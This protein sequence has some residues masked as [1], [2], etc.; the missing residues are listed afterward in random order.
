MTGKV[1]TVE[2]PLLTKKSKTLVFEEN[3]RFGRE[4]D[5]K[6]AWWSSNP[7]VAAAPNGHIFVAD[8]SEN[9]IMEYDAQGKWV[10]QLGGPGEGPGE[11]QLLNLYHI[12]E[13][14]MGVA[15]DAE[16]E[17]VSFSTFTKEGVFLAKEKPKRTR[18]NRAFFM[19]NGP[20]MGVELLAVEKDRVDIINGVTNH[21][22]DLKI[23]VLTTIIPPW[24]SSKAEDPVILGDRLGV[25]INVKAGPRGLVGFGFKG[26]VYT[27][28]S[29]KYEI[30]RWSA[31]LKT[32][33]LL[34]RKQYK[35][36]FRSPEE[37][38]M[39]IE[40]LAA[41]F[42]EALKPLAH[43]IT[44]AMVTKS[45]EKSGMK[46]THDPLYGLLVMPDG[47][48][49]AVLPPS[50]EGLSDAD[51]FNKDGQYVGKTRLPGHQLIDTERKPRMVFRNGFAYTLEDK[52]EMGHQVVRYSY[53]W[54]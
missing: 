39:I 34:I 38:A 32:R 19:P 27:A 44:I 11:F 8:P 53:A 25:I 2:N 21:E 5:E 14:G 7:T 4:E 46:A 50:P 12:Y 29:S 48:L 49:L 1:A 24:D 26:E 13:D 20:A 35:P 54:K 41:Q 9:R 52:G 40:S 17:I 45:Y 28:A 10:R 51:I 47:H 33:Q 30:T 18:L 31:D 42:R 36:R 6:Y 23:N 16:H 3:L 15:V 22:G 43:T 37:V